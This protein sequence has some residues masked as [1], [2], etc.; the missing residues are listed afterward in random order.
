[1]TNEN[2]EEKIIFTA[3]QVFVEKGYE[4]T[5][6]SDIA[7]RVGINRPTLHYYFRTK[8]RLFQAIFRDVVNS[9]F[10]C[11]QSI[12][13]Q[14]TNFFNKISLAL[15][16][17][18]LLFKGNTDLPAFVFKEIHRDVDHL[19]YTARELEIDNLIGQIKNMIQTEMDAG[20]IRCVKIE[21]IFSIFYGLM[22]FPFVGKNII[23]T[24][25]LHN[26]E[27][28]YNIYLNE[29]KEYVLAQMKSLLEP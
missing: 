4:E 25:L 17:Y 2:I 15:D 10:P 13:N 11:I 6:M 12:I 1:M 22:I 14:D 29:W 23:K 21:I 27:E 7:T 16:Q 5:C 20:R 19:I 24:I 26:S 18:I 8:E 3:R 9:L 28:E